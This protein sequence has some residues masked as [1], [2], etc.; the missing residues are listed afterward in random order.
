MNPLGHR[1]SHTSAITQMCHMSHAAAAAAAAHA[2][3]C[4]HESCT[5]LCNVALH[6]ILLPPSQ[7][8]RALIRNVS[9]FLAA[10]G[11]SAA[12]LYAIFTTGCSVGTL[13]WKFQTGAPM[14]SSP[15]L[16]AMRPFTLRAIDVHTLSIQ[17]AVQR[18]L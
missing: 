8:I 4:G 10:I 16:D 15:I 1:D 9:V 3:P 5:L 2:A 7:R 13:K 12:A 14:Y 17:R 6:D 11:I 18:A